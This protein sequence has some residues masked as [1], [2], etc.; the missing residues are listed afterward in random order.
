MKSLFN[1][2]VKEGYL[3]INVF[4]SIQMLKTSKAKCRTINQATIEKLVEIIKVDNYYSQHA[5][6]YLA[7]IDTFRFT[8]IRRRQLI[9][10]KWCDIDFNNKTLYLNS[11][12]S[13]NGNDNLVPINKDLIHHFIAIKNKS[14]NPKQ[15]EQVFNITK[16]VNNYKETQM[17]EAH[18]SSLISE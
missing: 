10:I 14:K 8:G 3:D 18:V 6:F 17:N 7:M 1:F 15:S 12:F 9:G 11:E 13:K 16:F 4:Q 5:W 2:A